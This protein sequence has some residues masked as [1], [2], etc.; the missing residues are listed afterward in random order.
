M[1]SERQCRICLDS[2]EPLVAPCRCKGSVS[3]VHKKCLEEWKRQAP[4][5]TSRVQCE[6]CKSF[7]HMGS[8]WF[9]RR[10]GEF[11]SDD[12]NDQESPVSL[13]QGPTTD[14][15]LALCW[16]GSILW[17]MSICLVM[18]YLSGLTGS[19]A[20]DIMSHL[21]IAP[22]SGLYEKVS[23]LGE[24]L[25]WTRWTLGP[26]FLNGYHRVTTPYRLVT[27]A[28]LLVVARS[29]TLYIL[30][31][32]AQLEYIKTAEMGS[33]ISLILG[34]LRLRERVKYRAQ[35]IAPKLMSLLY[36]VYREESS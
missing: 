8:P 23:V 15:S 16:T 34:F 22:D 7:Y 31:S 33:L 30:K 36:E 11:L 2:S 29:L 32:P 14:Y 27:L 1:T 19:M 10:S 4:Q 9:L 17:I 28:L 20:L 26:L 25:F 35:R 18:F 12:P 24:Q 6:L 21:Q 3:L 13:K 5:S